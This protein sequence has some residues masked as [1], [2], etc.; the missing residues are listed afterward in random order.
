M[1]GGQQETALELLREAAREG[2]WL[3]LKNLHLVVAWLPTLE[4]AISSLISSMQPNFRLWL[5]TE[6]HK[7][8]PPI[9]LQ[10]SLKITFESPP[11]IKKNMQRT[12]TSWGRE[13]VNGLSALSAVD[14]FCSCS[15][16]S[17][18]SFKSAEL[19]YL[20]VGVRRTSSLWVISELVLWLWTQ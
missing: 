8:F 15:H 12:L 10:T 6:P 11:G 18:L 20:R 16:G 7:D 17:T 19:T 14:N 1:G 4:K 9:L 2:D 3:C 5:T 13:F